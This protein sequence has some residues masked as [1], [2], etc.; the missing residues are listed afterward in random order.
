[1]TSVLQTIL[2]YGWW[3][4]VSGQGTSRGPIEDGRRRDPGGRT[5]FAG[6]RRTFSGTSQGVPLGAAT[7]LSEV[8]WTDTRREA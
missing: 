8:N 7:L 6:T 1:M 2:R 5:H 4:L 3:A